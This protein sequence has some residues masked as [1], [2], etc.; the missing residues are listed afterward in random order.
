LDEDAVDGGVVVELGELLEE[1]RLADVF[2][3]GYELALDIGLA[4]DLQRGISRAEY[5]GLTSSAAFSFIFTYVP[6]G[7]NTTHLT[8]ASSST[9]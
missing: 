9:H 4:L 5:I 2:G 7:V 8:T 1:L 6:V 3:E